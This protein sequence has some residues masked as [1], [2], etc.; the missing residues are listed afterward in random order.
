MTKRMIVLCLALGLLVVTTV[1]VA[2]PGQG[3][4][5]GGR[6][7]FGGPIIGKI[8][9]ANVAAGTIEAEMWGRATTLYPVQATRLTKF[10]T[11]ALADLKIGETLEVTGMPL[12]VQADRLRAPMP[13]EGQPQPGG[14]GGPGAG[15][16]AAFGMVD[17]G[18]RVTGVVKSL[19]PLVVTVASPDGQGTGTDVEVV[20]SDATKITREVPATWNEVAA[21]VTFRATAEMNE[22]QQLVLQT[23]A[24]DPEVADM[25]Q[26][27]A[28]MGGPGGGPGGP[29]GGGRGGRGGGN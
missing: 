25:L 29:G 28:Q 12:K 27:M 19:K 4:R 14:L 6:G 23:L 9:A 17:R 10:E 5:G 7:R 1:V 26:A 22:Q 21:G 20:A 13:A 3:G 15:M 16:A 8:T 11:V 24:L 2:Q 18:A